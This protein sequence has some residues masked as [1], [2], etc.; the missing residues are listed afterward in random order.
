MKQVTQEI[1]SDP[2]YRNDI[3]GICD[4]R[5]AS[6]DMGSP[7]IIKLAQFFLEFDNA[8][9]GKIAVIVNQPTATALSLIFKEQMKDKQPIDVFY[10]MTE[11][12]KFIGATKE[13]EMTFS[14]K[15]FIDIK[16][17]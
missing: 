8:T 7:G 10:T 17:A 14:R 11:A 13:M 2:D 4:L 12:R 16:A 9:E 5:K 6:F 3:S 1:W 15:K